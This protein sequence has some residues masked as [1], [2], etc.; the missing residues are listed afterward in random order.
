[1][2]EPIQP[3]EL[4][5]VRDAVLTGIPLISALIFVGVSVKVFRASNM[6]TST[7]VA[8]VS[9]ANQV[10]LLKGVVLT[11]LPGLLAGLA[12]AGLW[13]WCAAL[14]D[15]S[16]SLKQARSALT[17]IKYLV[18]WLLIAVAFFTVSWPAFVPLG[19][20]MLMLTG[21]LLI[22]IVTK[23]KSWLERAA[24]VATV[25]RPLCVATALVSVGWLALAPTVWL[26]LRQV[27]VLPG[28]SVTF[29]GKALPS[30][31]SAYILDSNEHGASLLLNS[32]RAVVQVGPGTVAPNPQICVPR[33]SPDRDWFLRLSQV[34]H[35]DPDHHSPYPV[36]SD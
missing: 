13:W 32:P 14:C 31:F 2:A 25:I 17:N 18:A 34:L 21:L 8:I 5:G 29:D 30:T 16:P 26:P 11:L 9:T 10:L 12:A 19:F 23:H 3:R 27:Q 7:T 24:H 20:S 6:E 36:C 15:R 22:G 28:Q 35:I 1:M 4:A 33:A